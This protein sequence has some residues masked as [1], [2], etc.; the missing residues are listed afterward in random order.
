[1]EKRHAD[2]EDYYKLVKREFSSNKKGE[3]ELLLGADSD[4][5]AYIEAFIMVNRE[6]VPVLSFLENWVHSCDYGTM[7][8]YG[9]PGSGKTTLCKKAIVEFYNGNFL[10]GLATNVLDVSLNIGKNPRIIRDGF[11]NITNMLSLRIGTDS[12]F[13]FDDCHGA[14]LFID[15]FDEFIDVARMAG[16]PDIVAFMQLI[17]EYAENYGIHIV[18]LSRT[19]AIE[20]HLNDTRFEK[21]AYM[22]MPITKQQQYAWL[23]RHSEYNDYYATFKILRNN[24]MLNDVLGNPFLFRLFIHSRFDGTASNIIELYDKLFRH[25]MAK[26]NIRGD[27]Q[28]LTLHKLCNLA[29]EIYC[30]D[31]DTAEL[32]G[33]ESDERWLR[34]LFIFRS[35]ILQTTIWLETSLDY[36]QKENWMILYVSSYQ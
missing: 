30:Y 13:T 9:E 2:F 3:Y 26:R 34:G 33:I 28:V 35:S 4:E 17:D 11:F 27:S 10:K 21:K 29:Y 31:T 14:L 24:I 12:R 25:L 32:G 20:G 18:V 19:L 1:M 15:D 23:E 22:L 36:L 7:L 8:I 16:I 6:L 5:E